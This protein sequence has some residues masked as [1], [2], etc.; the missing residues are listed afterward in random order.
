MANKNMSRILSS[1]SRLFCLLILLPFLLLNC[2]TAIGSSHH[3]KATVTMTTTNHN[4]HNHNRNNGNGPREELINFVVVE[5]PA[6]VEVPMGET[7]AAENLQA[8]ENEVAQENLAGTVGIQS[9][10]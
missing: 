7:A 4:S 10:H 8:I 1:A 5:E 2:F 3:S 9:F 6:E